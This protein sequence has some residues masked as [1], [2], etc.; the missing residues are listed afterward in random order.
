MHACAFSAILSQ[1]ALGAFLLKMLAWPHFHF[2]AC[3][4][5]SFLSSQAAFEWHPKLFFS[6]SRFGF[7]P[8]VHWAV[9]LALFV[10]LFV[11]LCLL[12]KFLSDDLARLH[13]EVHGNW[14]AGG[15][16]VGSAAVSIG[17]GSPGA[18]EPEFS[19]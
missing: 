3:L 9:V 18:S 12:L 5:A 1:A 10:A 7:M 2:E 14:L 4:V 17:R 19:L 16:T 11:L 6:R 13:A 8:E 15:I